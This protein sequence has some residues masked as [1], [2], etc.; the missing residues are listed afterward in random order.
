MDI[1]SVQVLNGPQGTLFG[2]SSAA[3]SILIEP[4]RPNLSETEASLKVRFGDYGRQE[5]T[6][7]LNVPITDRLAV[8]LAANSTDIE[9]YTSEI[10]SS[11]KLDEQQ[12]QQVRLGIQF[13]SGR[14]TS[15]TA[16]SYIHVD[17][18]A[19]G[20][21]LSAINLNSFP[22]NLPPVFAPFVYG[23]T[24]FGRGGIRVQSRC[25][26]LRCGAGGYRR[27]H[28]GCADRRKFADS[29]G[30]RLGNPPYTRCY[31]A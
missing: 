17:Q 21:V 9:G 13:E 24:C 10:G 31:G 3:G 12:N 16:A 20:Q 29:N 27:G 5:F 28:H 6:G 18:T 26:E 4:V 25:P 22:Y 11:R 19:P 30:R 23:P 1:A 7:T 15:Y 2:R 14:F 8:R